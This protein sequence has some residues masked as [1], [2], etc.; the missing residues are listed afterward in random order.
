L[1]D[2][3]GGVEHNLQPK[4]SLV[5]LC[6]VA[7]ITITRRDFANGK[8][9]KASTYAKMVNEKLRGECDEYMST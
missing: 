4:P 1:E 5:E 6:K 7:Y 9:V 8:D 3:R 2:E